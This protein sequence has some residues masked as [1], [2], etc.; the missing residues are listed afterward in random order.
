MDNRVS[1]VGHRVV[2]GGP[3]FWQPTLIDDTVVAALDELVELR[4]STTGPVSERF[5][6]PGHYSH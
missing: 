2:H 6:C 4:R 3:S 1:A 5:R